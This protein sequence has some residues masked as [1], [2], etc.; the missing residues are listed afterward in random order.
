MPKLE[1]LRGRIEGLIVQQQDGSFVFSDPEKNAMGGVAVLAAIDGM[2]GPAISTAKA[3]TDSTEPADYVQFSIAGKQIAGWLWFNPF[4]EGDEIEAVVEQRGQFFHVYAITRPKDRLIALHPHCSRGR[5]AHWKN[6]L[7]WCW[8]LG[9]GFGITMFAIFAT[10]GLFDTI[11]TA[12]YLELLW[13]FFEVSFGSAFAMAFITTIILGNKW[14]HFV[15]LAEH[16]F[17]ALD[18]KNPESID[19]PKTSKTNKRDDEPTFSGA[20]G[21]MFF[22]Y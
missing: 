21:T 12:K 4:R 8:K 22:R 7:N 5:I 14:M 10:I 6:A 18:W 2:D 13:F 1:V 19:L 16:M 9:F 15:K 20:Y 17:Y 11:S 3:A